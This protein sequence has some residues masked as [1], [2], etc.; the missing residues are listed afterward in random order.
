METLQKT[1]K[2]EGYEIHYNVSGK[3][4]T[5]LI[6]FLHPAFSDHRAFNPQIDFFAKEYKVITIDLI[7]HG[8]SKANKSKDK[9]D[10]SSEHI[11][12][13]I[14]LEGSNKAHIVGSSM[15]SLIAQYFALH[16]PDKVKS[17]TVLGGY[18]INKENKEV[19]KAQRSSNINLVLLALF[20]MQAFRK[21]VARLTCS[22]E[23]GQALFYDSTSRYT[24]KSFMSMQGLQHVI[25]NR[26]ASKV[27]YPTLLLTG[28]YDIEL[29]IKM[30]KDWHAHLENSQYKVIQNAGHC[31]N[32]DQPLDFNTLLKEFIS[33][34]TNFL[35]QK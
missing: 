5:G 23:K 9:I 35:A 28:E 8:L 20:S 7:G 31:A 32:L 25:K 4:N 15:G 2:K 16:Y 11:F 17:L 29:A 22:S 6:I 30:A 13:I 27:D 26:T 10:A 34:N 12:E 14:E 3:E 19:I 21:K 1:L 18:D 33:S 24:R